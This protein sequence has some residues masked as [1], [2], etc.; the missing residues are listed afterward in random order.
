MRVHEDFAGPSPVGELRKSSPQRCELL[1]EECW[2]CLAKSKILHKILLF[3]V[4]ENEVTEV[5]LRLP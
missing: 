1:G 2:A 4:D 5:L 3:A